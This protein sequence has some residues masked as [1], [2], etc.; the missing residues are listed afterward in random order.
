MRPGS[1]SLD[2]FLARRAGDRRLARLTHDLCLPEGSGLE[3]GPAD[4][5]TPLPEGLSVTYVD[6]SRDAGADLAGATPIDHAW[7]GSGSLTAVLGHDGY[8]FAIAAQVGQYVPNLLGWL[9]GIHAALRPGGVLNLSLPDRQFMFDA[10][11]PVSTLA[12]L[13]EA[14][15]LAYERPSPRQMF[16]HTYDVRTITPE[17]IWAGEDPVHAP[18]MAGEAALPHA[19]AEAVD[20]L[21][22]DAYVACHCWVLTPIAFL[23]LVEGATRLDLFPFVLNQVSATQLGG[24]EFYVS[25]RREAQAEA[26]ALLGLQI[27]AIN[28]LRGLLETQRQTAK[29]MAGI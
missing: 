2:A 12:E 1:L 24:F 14:D 29:L 3:F 23:D 4:N 22:T 9:R 19:H 20:A 26:E 28:H 21:A 5:P 6:H 17:Q 25:M 16:G 11:R 15:L 18:R 13:I 8:D 7:S 10:A 27:G